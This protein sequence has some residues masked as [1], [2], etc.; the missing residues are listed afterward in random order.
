MSAMILSTQAPPV[1]SGPNPQ[2]RNR[3]MQYGKSKV[4]LQ[5]FM[6]KPAS[7]ETADI[8]PVPA[9]KSVIRSVDDGIKRVR[10]FESGSDKT[11]NP[12]EVLAELNRLRIGSS[13]AA[14]SAT[15]NSTKISDDSNNK[16][17]NPVKPPTQEQQQQEP[18]KKAWQRPATKSSSGL[19]NIYWRAVDVEDLRAHPYFDRYK[20]V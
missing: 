16:A 18:P 5:P 15:Q 9:A 2:N 17:Q 19:A 8:G 10:V 4:V 7:L 6:C 11:R 20:H 12:I 14:S 1:N 3:R 13:T